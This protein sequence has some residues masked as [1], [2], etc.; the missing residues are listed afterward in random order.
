M[1][2]NALATV[3]KTNASKFQYSKFSKKIEISKISIFCSSFNCFETAQRTLANLNLATIDYAAVLEEY[4]LVRWL[5][6]AINAESDTPDDIVLEAV[7]L[8]QLSRD[9]Q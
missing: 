1:P 3:S 7:I 4:D 6:S 9:R 8:G 2:S 5:K